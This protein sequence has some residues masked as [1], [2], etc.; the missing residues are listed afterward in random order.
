MSD[1]L[2]DYHRH[3]PPPAHPGLVE[4]PDDGLG[5]IGRSLGTVVVLLLG[6]ASA[7]V[8]GAAVV[9]AVAA[10][11]LL[12]PERPFRLVAVALAVPEARAFLADEMADDLEEERSVPLASTDRAALVDA[13]DDVLASPELHRQLRDLRAEGDSIEW[14]ELLTIYSS[15]LRAASVGTPPEVRRVLEELATA[16]PPELQA[17]GGSTEVRGLRDTMNEVRGFVLVAALV[18]AVPGL[19]VG[20]LAVAGARRRALAAVLVSS[21]A[22]LLAVVALAPGRPLLERLPGPLSLPGQ[23]MAGVGELAGAGAMWALVLAI[24]VPPGL[25]WALRS[26]RERLAAAPTT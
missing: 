26:W 18:L 5:S 4:A 17:G 7:V 2:T 24:A 3:A 9:V 15:E 1:P 8:L 20:A 14:T 21:G 12:S 6:T 10:V 16:A 11:T 23:L 25:W 22:L 13:L 19:V